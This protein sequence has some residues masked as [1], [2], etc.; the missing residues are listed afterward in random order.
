[1]RAG[2]L[3]VVCLVWL[4]E[5]MRMMIDFGDRKPQRQRVRTHRPVQQIPTTPHPSRQSVLVV[6]RTS[7]RRYYHCCPGHGSAARRTP[8]AWELAQKGRKEAAGLVSALLGLHEGHDGDIGQRCLFCCTK[9]L[10]LV[11]RQ[12]NKL[13]PS[14]HHHKTHPTTQRARPGHSKES[15]AAGGKPGETDMED[16]DKTMLQVCDKTENECWR[17]VST[18]DSYNGVCCRPPLPPLLNPP[19]PTWTRTLAHVSK[20]TCTQLQKCFPAQ[21]T[22]LARLDKFERDLH[23]KLLRKRRLSTQHMGRP[24]VAPATQTLRIYVHHRFV[25]PMTCSSSSLSSRESVIGSRSRGG[26]GSGNGGRGGR[27]GGG[28]EGGMSLVLRI[29]GGVLPAA[30]SAGAVGS[31]AVQCSPHYYFTEF[32]DRVTVLGLQQEVST[33]RGGGAVDGGGGE[34]GNEVEVCVVEG[35]EG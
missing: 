14:H 33:R 22:R 1:M 35:E 28:G 13:A 15:E 20:L 32:F 2:H 19:S 27:D 21:A 18:I 30:A 24:D 4:Y 12:L 31:D 16:G 10:S 29:E 8:A 17:A 3:F 7:K 34:D 11:R 5:G 25:R 9:R 6:W 26:D 23:Y